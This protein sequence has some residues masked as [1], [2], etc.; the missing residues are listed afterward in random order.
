MKILEIYNFLLESKAT[1]M[2]GLYEKVKAR[3][4]ELLKIS[5]NEQ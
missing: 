2:Q 5:N 4:E 3:C 1:E